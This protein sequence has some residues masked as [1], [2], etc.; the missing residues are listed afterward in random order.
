MI[1]LELKEGMYIRF[2]DKRGIQ[3]I[4]KIT[5]INTEKPDKRYAAIFIDKE[6][7]NCNGVS[8]KNI[9]GK[10]SF[11]LID[12]IKTGDFVNGVRVIY[13][14]KNRDTGERLIITGLY[15][16]HQSVKEIIDS[17]KTEKVYGEEN[18]LKADIVTKEQFDNAK[19]WV[20]R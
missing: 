3:Y 16:K 19:Y 15:E 12:L 10:P 9:I 5:S 14:I 11:D 7:N 20:E 8:L 18:L 6:A 4:R 13:I 1:N 17:E 2:K